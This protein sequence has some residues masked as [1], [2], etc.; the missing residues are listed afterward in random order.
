[1]NKIGIVAGTFDPFTWGHYS[2]V[3]KALEVFSEVHILIADNPKKKCMFSKDMRKVMCSHYFD[4][5][6][7][8]IVSWEGLT[9]D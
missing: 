6:S 1:M 5:E 3:K 2:V 4:K 9:V 8:V 7:V